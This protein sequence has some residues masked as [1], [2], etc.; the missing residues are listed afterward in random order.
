MF[1]IVVENKKLPNY[2]TEKV[3]DCFLAHTFPLYHGCSNF[4]EFFDKDSFETIDI[5][6]FDSSVN[7]IKKNT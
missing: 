5:N 1:S 6:N 7:T 3:V 4:K 2:F